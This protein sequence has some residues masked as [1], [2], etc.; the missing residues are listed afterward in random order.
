MVSADGIAGRVMDRDF[1]ITAKLR[2]I[3]VEIAEGYDVM[4][5]PIEEARFRSIWLPIAVSV[6]SITGY[7]WSLDAEVVSMFGQ[8]I[9][10]RL[11]DPT[12]S[13]SPFRLYYSSSWGL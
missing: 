4:S 13:I 8:L 9:R 5:F 12:N 3:P 1:R 7:G 6:A 10:E 11:A 2:G